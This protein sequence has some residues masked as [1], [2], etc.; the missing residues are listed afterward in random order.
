[1]DVDSY[2][3]HTENVLCV[4]TS[5]SLNLMGS[6]IIFEPVEHFLLFECWLTTA[7]DAMAICSRAGLIK[8]ID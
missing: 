3:L 7:L 4:Y 2:N 5:G 8:S 6:I 1:M